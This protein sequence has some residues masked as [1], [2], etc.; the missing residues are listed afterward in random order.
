LHLTAQRCCL[1]LS[2]SHIRA[3]CADVGIGCRQLL[4]QQF[5]LKPLAG[6]LTLQF[7]TRRPNVYGYNKL[8][9]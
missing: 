8:L 9:A 3:Q 2:L 7:K 4:A 6:G 1:L 5:D